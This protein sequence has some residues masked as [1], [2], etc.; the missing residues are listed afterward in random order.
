MKKFIG[1]III[2]IATISVF[3]H[4]LAR[5]YIATAS[6]NDKILQAK[7]YILQF[8]SYPETVIFHDKFTVINKNMVTIRFTYT[9]GFGVIDT[10]TMDIEVD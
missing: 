3:D 1:L 5:P 2:S 6:D 9:N 7:S 8:V 10:L 4:C